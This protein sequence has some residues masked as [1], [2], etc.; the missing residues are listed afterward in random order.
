MDSLFDSEELKFADFLDGSADIALSIN[1]SFNKFLFIER[2]L[3]KARELERL[4]LKYPDKANRIEIV[5]ADA[6]DYLKKWIEKTNWSS[7]RAVVFIDPFG[8][9]VEWKLLEAIANTKAIDLWLLVPIGMGVNRLMTQT[10]LPPDDWQRR[11][12]IFLG[13]E[14]WKEKFY[15]PN[16][17]HNLFGEESSPIKSANYSEL[18]TYFVERLRSIFDEDGVAPKPL[19]QN[20]S[21]NSPM[22]L[23]C[24][25]SGNKN[26]VKIAHWL[27]TNKPNKWKGGT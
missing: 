12:T 27:L 5:Q 13:N 22:Y 6:N 15:K 16:S 14:E 18:A 8:M 3:T 10:S 20:N 4:K 24:F 26:G 7:N 9:Q 11:L 19:T 17:S 2:S 23:L 1:P 21:N 25:A